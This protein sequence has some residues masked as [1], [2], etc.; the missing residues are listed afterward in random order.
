MTN[1]NQCVYKDQPW[2]ITGGT[3]VLSDFRNGFYISTDSQ[4]IDAPRAC[5]GGSTVSSMVPD[6]EDGE[7][8]VVC[9]SISWIG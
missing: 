8:R 6:G 7:F 1:S 2:A 5:P 9:G 4:G 3:K